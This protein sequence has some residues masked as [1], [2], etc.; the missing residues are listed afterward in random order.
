M[1][2][3]THVP[4]ITHEKTWVDVADSAVFGL[5]IIFVAWAFLK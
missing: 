5:V 1:N 3:E 2:T 4:V